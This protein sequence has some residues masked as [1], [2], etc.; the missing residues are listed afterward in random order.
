MTTA[1]VIVLQNLRD[2]SAHYQ[3]RHPTIMGNQNHRHT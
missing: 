3:L 1:V 2:I